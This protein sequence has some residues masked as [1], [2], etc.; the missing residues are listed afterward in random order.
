M[1]DMVA[2]I[3]VHECWLAFSYGLGTR[4][5]YPSNKSPDSGVP[6]AVT[7]VINH[8]TVGYPGSKNQYK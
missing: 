8:P 3:C 1:A 2:R 5:G 6:V 7:R 4:H